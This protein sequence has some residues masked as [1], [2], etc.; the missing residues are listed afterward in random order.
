MPSLPVKSSRRSLCVCGR[1]SCAGVPCPLSLCPWWAIYRESKGIIV[2]WKY[3]NRLNQI[4]LN[5]KSSLAARLGSAFAKLEV[6]GQLIL[7]I[8]FNPFHIV[9]RS[10]LILLHVLGESRDYGNQLPNLISD[11]ILIGFDLDPLD[12]ISSGDLIGQRLTIADPQR[13][14]PH[15]A[16][17]GAGRCMWRSQ[18]TALQ[19]S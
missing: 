3:R 18:K 9:E 5:L 17:S 15:R 13:R 4:C 2:P 16:R 12:L 19:W 7:L 6:A 8:C 14:C 11:L 1:S 10:P